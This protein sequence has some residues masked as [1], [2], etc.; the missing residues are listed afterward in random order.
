M[1]RFHRDMLGTTDPKSALEPEVAGVA[2]IN[3]FGLEALPASSFHS[4]PL[5]P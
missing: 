2:S 5:P 3:R 1:K 4:L